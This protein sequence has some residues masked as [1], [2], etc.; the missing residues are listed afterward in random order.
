[1]IDYSAKIKIKA[2][3]SVYNNFPMPKLIKGQ[4][5]SDKTQSFSSLSHIKINIEEVL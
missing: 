1:M 4:V 5:L 2:M 3:E